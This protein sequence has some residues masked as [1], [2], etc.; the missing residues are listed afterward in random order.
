MYFYQN[1][2]TRIQ[3]LRKSKKKFKTES[4]KTLDQITSKYFKRFWF[5]K[6]FVSFN[7][8]MVMRLI[9]FFFENLQL[10]AAA[11]ILAKIVETTS[12][13]VLGS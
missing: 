11:M 8:F 3:K 5:K 10:L 13:R 9:F 2:E 1:I 6:F 4:T 7:R 12:N